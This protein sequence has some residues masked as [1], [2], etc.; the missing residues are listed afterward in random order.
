MMHAEQRTLP[1]VL[2][3]AAL[4]VVCCLSL[5][6]CAAVV[7]ELYQEPA[8]VVIRPELAIEP[9]PIGRERALALDV[10]DR[11]AKNILGY[12]CRLGLVQL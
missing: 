5:G 6:A 3:G 12:R 11:R 8:E 7:A 4:L 10:V 9:T 2:L 1:T